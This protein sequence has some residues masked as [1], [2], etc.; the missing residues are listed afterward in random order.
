MNT[1]IEKRGK[2]KFKDE[3]G[4]KYR[5][6]TLEE[7][8]AAGGIAPNEEVQVSG[9]PYTVPVEDINLPSEIEEEQDEN[10][11]EEDGED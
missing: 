9:V 5:F 1:I 6:K 3:N 7:A 8:V 4:K 11:E 2:Y 10:L